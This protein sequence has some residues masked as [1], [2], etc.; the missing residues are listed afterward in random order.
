MDHIQKPT[1]NWKNHL[2]LLVTGCIKAVD[3]GSCLVEAKQTDPNL[4]T[5]LRH[6]ADNLQHYDGNIDLNV[7]LDRARHWFA[8]HVDG[9]FLQHYSPYIDGVSWHNEIWANSQNDH[10]RLE[11]IVGTKAAIQVWNQEYRSQARLAHIKLVVGEAAVGNWIP[12]EVI[13]MAIKNDCLVGYHPYSAYGWDNMPLQR[14]PHDWENLSGLWDVMEYDYGL[15]PTW[16]F[17]EAGPFSGPVTGWKSGDVC[18]GDLNLYVE[19][20]R[21]WI[22]DVQLT[23]AYKEGRIW[24]FNIFTTGGG[25]QWKTFETTARELD[26]LAQMYHEVW[27]PGTAPPPPPDPVPYVVVVN[28]LDQNASMNDKS[29]VLAKVHDQKETIVQSADDAARLV[30]PGKTGSR[31]KVWGAQRWPAD[32]VKWLKDRGVERVDLME[33]ASLKILDIVEDLATNPKSQWYPYDKRILDRIKYLTIHHSVGIYTP[34]QI[35]SGHCNRNGGGV[36]GWPGIGYHFVITKDGK[37]YQTNYLETVSFHSGV[38]DHP[39]GQYNNWYSV[40]ICLIGDFTNVPPTPE[41]L[42]SA[43]ALVEYL[44]G[45]LPY[46]P[47]EV[48]GHKEMP[49]AATQCPGNTW[50]NWDDYVR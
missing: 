28:L 48:R 40:G 35:A 14:W 30:A 13:E 31:V 9:T 24:G 5:L 23:P 42:S 17:T 34:Y 10:E 21:A 25:D 36:N 4:K 6:W 22:Y 3:Q 44:K 2:P 38:K 45:L 41:Q 7:W 49:G 39:E 20:M 1:P 46:T 26:A 47:M 43:A 18:G 50:P 15:K 11:R 32:I 27:H 16:V 12:R 37:V 19:A 33:Y 8:T 29:H